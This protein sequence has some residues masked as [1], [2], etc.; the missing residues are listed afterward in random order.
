MASTITLSQL[1]ALS[2]DDLKTLRKAVGLV[3][4]LKGGT[5]P[6]KPKK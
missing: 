5:T 2:V 3:L 6:R 1:D 4:A